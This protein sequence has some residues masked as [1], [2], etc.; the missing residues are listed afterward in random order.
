VVGHGKTQSLGEA[1]QKNLGF[2]DEGQNM[3]L[4]QSLLSVI[5]PKGLLA[6]SSIKLI[7]LHRESEICPFFKQESPNILLFVQ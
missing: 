4:V 3:V 6:H 1:V 7:C 5:N 2:E